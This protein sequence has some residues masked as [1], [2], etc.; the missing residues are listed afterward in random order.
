MHSWDIGSKQ[1]EF[2]LTWS[3]KGNFMG[4]KEYAYATW[5]TNPNQH[6]ASVILFRIGKLVIV[7]NNFSKGVTPYVI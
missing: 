1:T 5:L 2:C 7:L 4:L 3:Q 6:L